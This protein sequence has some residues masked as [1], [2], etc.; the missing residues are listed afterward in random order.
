MREGIRM[1]LEVNFNVKK[2]YQLW[3]DQEI[4]TTISGVRIEVKIEDEKCY[5]SFIGKE[6]EKVWEI[7][8]AVWE[9]LALY[10]GYFYMPISANID[11]EPYDI[12]K[13]YG[14]KFRRTDKFWRDSATLLGQG[15]RVIDENI[16]VEYMNL[17]N[18]GRIQGKMTKSVIN[19]YFNILSVAY[20]EIN[21][22]H[23]LSL[24][25]NACDGYFLNEICQSKGTGGHIVKLVGNIDKQKV[26]HMLELI[27]I[28]KSKITELFGGVRDEIDHY[29][30]MQYS[31]GSYIPSLKKDVGACLNLY[32]L[33]IVE[34]AMRVTLLERIGGSINQKAKERAVDFINDRLILRCKL[35]D[36]CRIPENQMEQ[37]FSKFLE[38]S[39]D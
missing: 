27:G 34:L 35:N 12:E 22:E 24:M 14:M 13:L 9:V 6:N 38:I 16:I 31:V 36:R 37:D 28:P 1:N 39:V 19:A 2:Y 20:K 32:L 30:I 17:R 15:D 7:F 4:E 10:D 3:S 26:Q 29:S 25:L 23:K 21:I 5:S 33:Y 8:Y 18:Q 11:G